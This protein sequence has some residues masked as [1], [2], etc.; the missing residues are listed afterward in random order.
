MRHSVVTR[1]LCPRGISHGYFQSFKSRTCPP[2]QLASRPGFGRT[3]APNPILVFSRNASK[4]SYEQKAKDLN[5]QGVDEALSDFDEA[6]AEQKDKQSRAP[7]HRQGADVPPVGRQRSA[8]AMTKGWQ[9]MIHF[10]SP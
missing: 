7:W 1:R 8:G 5:Q 4:V 9:R 10:R 2:S 6:I 3:Y